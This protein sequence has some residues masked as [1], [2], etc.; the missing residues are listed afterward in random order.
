[1]ADIAA[2]IVSLAAGM[3]FL[4]LIA[5]LVLPLFFRTGRR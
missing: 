5:A 1:M 3:T 4:G 2:Y